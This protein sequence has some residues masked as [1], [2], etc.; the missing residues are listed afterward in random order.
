MYIDGHVF[1]L[2]NERPIKSLEIIT[3]LNCKITGQ[4]CTKQ[5]VKL[6]HALSDVDLKSKKKNMVLSFCPEKFDMFRRPM[7]KYWRN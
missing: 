3:I 1:M 6:I 5:D 7:A 2:L 4:F